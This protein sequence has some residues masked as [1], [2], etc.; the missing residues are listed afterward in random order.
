MSIVEEEILNDIKQ[1]L[2][3]EYNEN[4]EKAMLVCAQRAI[5]S[6][7]NKRRYPSNYTEEIISKDME[8]Q[9]SC[10]FDICLYWAM[11][12]GVEFQKSNS[13]SGSSQSWD[14]EESIYA[15]HNVVSIA[16]IV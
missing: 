2:G 14:S 3:D 12:Q 16:T 11:K 7:K 10:L 13:E 15:L 9:K 6:F 8:N 4:S 1:Y 5:N